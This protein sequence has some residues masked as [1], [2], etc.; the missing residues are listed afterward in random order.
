MA[1]VKMQK[2]LKSEPLPDEHCDWML[3][4]KEASFSAYSVLELQ[5]AV[6]D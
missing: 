3:S 2:S 6:F 4:G 5:L 1:S